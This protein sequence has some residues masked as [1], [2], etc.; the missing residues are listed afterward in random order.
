VF[1]LIKGSEI[2]HARYADAAGKNGNGNT[3]AE[4]LNFGTATD[5]KTSGD[6]ISIQYILEDV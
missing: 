5:A 3:L 1:E 6:K 2:W 4:V